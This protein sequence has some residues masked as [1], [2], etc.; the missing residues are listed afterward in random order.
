[1]TRKRPFLRHRWIAAVSIGLLAT[2]G[3]LGTGHA[4]VAAD[5]APQSASSM[6]DA[7]PTPP[8]EAG[9]IPD[10][11]VVAGATLDCDKFR[12]AVARYAQ[13][14]GY[15][16]KPGDVTTQIVQTYNCGSSWIYVYNLG[17]RGNMNVAYGFNSTNGNVIYRNLAVG[18]S[19][20]VGWN[21]SAWMNSA[22]DDSGNR[23]VG[24]YN[25]GQY[26]SAS[27]SGWWGGTCTIPTIS[28]GAYL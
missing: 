18:T 25:V 19:G 21:D 11:A 24:R 15:C 22:Y 14:H 17:I 12:G 5:L 27:M 20:R 3:L 28:A 23:F 13:A 16:P 2:M 1:M 8:A 9:S 7:A 4:A 6:S 26:Q 10:G